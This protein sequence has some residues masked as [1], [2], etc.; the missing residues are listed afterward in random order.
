MLFRSPSEIV[1]H[2]IVESYGGTVC[3]TSVVEGISTTNILA[4]LARG[5]TTGA[6]QRSDQAAQFRRAS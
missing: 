5:E 1:G 3:V 4:S 6:V 2:E